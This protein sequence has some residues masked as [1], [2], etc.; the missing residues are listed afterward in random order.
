MGKEARAKR[1]NDLSEA[2]TSRGKTRRRV[3]RH[4]IVAVIAGAA[5]W[6]FWLS[7]PRW[8]ADMRLWKAVG[9]SSYVL[10]LGALAIGP[11]S[12]LLPATRPLIKWRRQIGV[13]FAIM[14]TIH[15]VLILNG[16]ARWSVRRFF[17][18]EF[19]PQLGREARMEPGFGLANLVGL[20]ALA[21][22]L[23]LAATSSDRV[24]RRIGR[25]AWTW[26]H[27]MAQTV[28]VLALVHGGYYLF[29]HFTLSFHKNPV[30]S[31]WFRIPFVLSGLAVVAMQAAGFVATTRRTRSRAVVD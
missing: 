25:P 16:W 7:R 2:G 9:D 21:L 24:L 5:V 10:L 26:L 12:K 23:L 1:S 30:P 31:D 17:G 20:V 11:L 8:S 15:G 13:W 27:R 18:Y 3:K 28:L 19:V 22:A 4:L 29:I 6:V 14:A